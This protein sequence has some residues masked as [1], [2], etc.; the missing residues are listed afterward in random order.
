MA[1]RDYKV[2]GTAGQSARKSR[3][4]GY[5]RSVKSARA[6]RVQSSRES[7]YFSKLMR[8]MNRKFITESAE[9]ITLAHNNGTGSKNVKSLSTVANNR[10]ANLLSTAASAFQAGRI[11]DYINASGVLVKLWLSN[12]LDRPNVM[13]RVLVIQWYHGF[14]PTAANN[15][16]KANSSPNLMIA[17]VDT[18]RFKVRYDRT[19]QSKGGFNA[20][21]TGT[22][23]VPS[24]TN[25]GKEF[26][27]YH[28]F[29][30][31]TPGIVRY[32]TDNGQIPSIEKYCLALYVFAYDAYGT[33]TTDNI[34]SCA[35]ETTFYWRDA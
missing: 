35:Y 18:D 32:Q 26:S 9:D 5:K 23:L 16:F 27:R 7:S 8:S 4:A 19:L 10:T 3:M 1:Y 21:S 13:Y 12:K 11:G 15:V 28:K 33:A 25:K 17:G 2:K 34:A 6:A 31:K 29:Y 14:D 24:N 20:S 30:L 22:E